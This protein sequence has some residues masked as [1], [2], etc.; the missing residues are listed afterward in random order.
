[1]SAPDHIGEDSPWVSGRG[2]LA[3]SEE[4]RR[5]G[6]DRSVRSQRRGGEGDLDSRVRILE[7]LSVKE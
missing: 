6:Q 3:R 5:P 2:L 4:R 1:M 7:T